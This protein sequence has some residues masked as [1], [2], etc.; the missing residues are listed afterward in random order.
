MATASDINAD[1]LR[2]A[3]ISGVGPRAREALRAHLGDP[4]RILASSQRELEQVPGI[5]R[6]LATRIRQEG[7]AVDIEALLALC[8]REDIAIIPA[9]ARAYPTLLREI[10]DPPGVLFVA[11]SLV[12]EDTMSV[13][14]VGTRHASHY[15]LRQAERIA[16]QLSRAGLTVVSG[17]ARGIDAAAHRGA[18]RAGGRTLAVLA[19]G[20]LRLYPPEHASLA[21][22]IRAAGAVISEAPP[23]RPPSSGTFPQRNRIITGLTLGVVVIEAGCRSGALIS[24]RHALDQGREVFALPGPVDSPVSRGCHQ[25]LRDGAKL[26]EDVDDILEEIGSLTAKALEGGATTARAAEP[27]GLNPAETIVWRVVGDQP[28]TI[29][30]VIR[31]SDLPVHQVLATLSVLELKRLITRVSGAIVQRR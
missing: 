20:L 25:L 31:A 18:L 12:P 10:P 8:T 22:Q 29:D 24:A 5:G 19:G 9:S 11:G 27:G 30:E 26:I 1:E 4:A 15:G 14:V 2:L 13:A 3:L 28:T 21:A 7:A 17:L 16:G 6:V 23:Q